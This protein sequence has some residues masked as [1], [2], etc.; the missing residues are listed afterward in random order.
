MEI[1]GEPDYTKVNNHQLPT[2]LEDCTKAS[3]KIKAI[4]YNKYMPDEIK[5]LRM[6]KVHDEIIETLKNK[7]RVMQ[8]DTIKVII[9]KS[10]SKRVKKIKKTKKTGE[11]EEKLKTEQSEEDNIQGYRKI[12]RSLIGWLYQ[13]HREAFMKV[14][15]KSKGYN[16]KEE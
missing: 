13:T 10:Y 11:I 6:R 7:I 2:I 12:R 15:E 8:E 4:Q 16:N 3:N 1:I 9:C 5:H 14:I